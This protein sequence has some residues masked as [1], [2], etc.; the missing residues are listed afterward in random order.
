MQRKRKACNRRKRREMRTVSLILSLG[1]LLLAQSPE[2]QPRG[3]ASEQQLFA[4]INQERE[5]AGLAKLHWNEQLAKAAREHARLLAVNNSLSHQF[6]GEPELAERIGG[7][8][9]RFTLAAENIGRADSPEEAHIGLMAS[10]GH[11]ANIL[12][13]TYN[14]VGIGTAES[15][16]H[17]FVAEDFAIVLLAFSEAQFRDALIQTVNR[18]RAAKRIF[19]LEI[20]DDSQLRAAACTAHGNIRSLTGAA[21]PYSETVLF[22]ISDPQV[23][24]ERLLE[25]VQDRRWKKLALGVCFHPDPQHGD[26]N[27]WVAAAFG[28]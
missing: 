28:S 23:L 15:Q 11:R 3:K 26:A 6:A 7:T 13:S 16:G 20:N 19:R 9:A 18:A 27:F 21:S 8:G 2:A 25:F 12:S 1:A 22:T 17:L 10:S 14:A 4:L 24:P 5:K